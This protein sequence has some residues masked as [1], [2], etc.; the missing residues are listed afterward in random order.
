MDPLFVE[1]LADLQAKMRLS[2][3][4]DEDAAG[5][6][7]DVASLIEVA[8]MK[9][10]VKLRRALG[11]SRIDTLLSYVQGS[12]VD[13]DTTH[14]YLRMTAELC[15]VDMVKLELTYILP[16]MFRDASSDAINV[17]QEEGAFRRADLDE[18]QDQRH[19]LE[20]DIKTYLD[21]LSGDQDFDD[22]SVNRAQSIGPKNGRR[23]GQSHRRRSRR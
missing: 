10:R 23:V 14:E 2:N 9:A 15:E 19:R 1:T 17:T 12:P 4:P 13:P 22:T 6:P 7:V 3:I 5:M 18:L 16:T 8:V 20:T 11:Q 21:A